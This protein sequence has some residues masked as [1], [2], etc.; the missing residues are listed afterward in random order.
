[1]ESERRGEASG[2]TSARPQAVMVDP[3]YPLPVQEP[4]TPSR[5]V[6]ESPAKDD[7]EPA[8]GIQ[9]GRT[10]SRRKA[11]GKQSHA[12]SPRAPDFLPAAPDVPISPRG[13]PVSYRDPYNSGDILPAWSSSNKS[14]A[15][16]AG[17][18]LD[19]VD[20]FLANSVVANRMP[21]IDKSRTP[22]ST[23]NDQSQGLNYARV[24]QPV[25]PSYSS[26]DVEPASPQTSSVAATPKLFV[27]NSDGKRAKPTLD[28]NIAPAESNVSSRP[29][30]LE[31][32]RQS[33]GVPER[34]TEWAPDRSPLQKLE[35]KLNDISKEEKR[36][37][38]Q[39]A[40][41][42][43]RESKAAK[44]AGVSATGHTATHRAASK[45]S[46][47][48][49]DNVETGV[50]RIRDVSASEANNVNRKATQN[51]DEKDSQQRKMSRRAHSIAADIPKKRIS[52]IPVRSVSQTQSQHARWRS[53][54]A[55]TSNH[56]DD[57][58][59]RF[60]TDGND[61]A[62]EEIIGRSDANTEVTE[63]R[64]PPF[65]SSA[66][67]QSSVN[68]GHDIPEQQKQMY[69]ERLDIPQGEDSAAAYGGIPD[70]VSGQQSQSRERTPKYAVPPQTA[71][72]ITARQKIGF[73]STADGP[74]HEPENHG[75]HISELLHLGRHK[76]E[77][78]EAAYNG[79]PR[80]LNDWRTGGV[81]RL[82]LADIISDEEVS[83]TKSA[84]RWERDGSGTRGG[85]SAE[86]RAES[87]LSAIDG[88]IE[89]GNGMVQI[90]SCE[91]SALSSLQ[92]VRIRRY[93][94][95]TEYMPT[96]R[97][98]RW[99]RQPASIVGLYRSK[100][101]Q[102]T[103]SSS[104]SYSCPELAEHDP[105]HLNHICKPYMSKELTRSMRS[106]R[107]RAPAA[108]ITFDPPL[109]L[110]CGPLL[111]YTG[112]KRDKLERP[113]SR[114]ASVMERET[115]R[116]SVMIVTV[117]SESTYNPVPMLRLFHQPMDLLPPPPQQ[118]D[119]VGGE[120]LPSE[121]VD[122]IAGLPKMTR[123][124]GTV[125]VKPV[126]DLDEGVDVS[127]VED[128]DGLYE[129]TRTA[130]V[131]T[132]YGKADELLNRSPHP[133]LSKN[134]ASQN[135]SRR[136]GKVQEV[137]GV[138]LHAERGVTF[139]RFNLEVELGESQA[140]IA[141]RINKAASIGFWVPARGQS[142][143]IMFHSCNGF[144]LSVK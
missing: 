130:N 79:P 128:D 1:M 6:H 118:F 59:V 84:A 119:G 92:C 14:F 88:G 39:E 47:S 131:P 46:A 45:H 143:N 94:G 19:K 18:T 9:L 38:V 10:T 24:Q 120:D 107:V 91:Y 140:R 58:S 82:T 78:T 124:G 76:S 93:I 54:A 12:Q 142:M 7:R 106:I 105:S 117:D 40:E 141:Y 5:V 138:K 134:R 30:H 61:R 64:S 3:R 48:R 2:Y 80:H 41:Q 17:G 136:P 49:T 36:A 33:A 53:A 116:G 85:T 102:R 122:P 22:R 90:S 74:S 67:G 129:I 23:N 112:L 96:R 28:T 63:L 127:R 43:L 66:E 29:V 62:A 42:L 57:R 65:Q 104:Y 32:T 135:N 123:S 111:R 13:P 87:E 98:S 115:W 72:G 15:A 86:L 56:E 139:W 83:T 26:S 133:I 77:Q 31:T 113:G 68:P 144:S 137:K 108:P 69:I 75:H 70:P 101:M 44:A 35:V 11:A 16:R 37:R 60:Q 4:I 89:N 27:P 50:S 20:S 21:T 34:R 100:L 103:L 109:F 132:G 97:R 110:K 73:G 55:T 121:Y 8:Q 126:E 125:Y 71:S 99:L 114:N 81:A 25:L 52:R 51:A 95:D